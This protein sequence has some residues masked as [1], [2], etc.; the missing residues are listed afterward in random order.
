MPAKSR[1][2]GSGSKPS[3]ISNNY[4]YRGDRLSAQPLC[5]EVVHGSYP[6]QRRAIV[7]EREED[8]DVLL[9]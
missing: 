9:L 1:L 8:D 2:S 4:A 7:A 5:A 3:V 6:R